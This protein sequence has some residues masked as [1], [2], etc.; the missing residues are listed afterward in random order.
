MLDVKVLSEAGRTGRPPFAVCPDFTTFQ[1]A[2]DDPQ[3]GWWR[4][5]VKYGTLAPELY[6][7]AIFKRPQVMLEPGACT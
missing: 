7:H 2:T 4:A 1:P 3:H 5:F 6:A